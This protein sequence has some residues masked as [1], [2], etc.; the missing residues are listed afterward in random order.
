MKL[1]TP[2]PNRP[3][4]PRRLPKAPPSEGPPRQPKRSLL[5][6]AGERV[7]DLGYTLSALPKFI[8]P[9]I[10]GATA[11]Q[12]A[13]IAQSLDKLPFHHQVLPVSI[14]VLPSFSQ[15]PNYLGL[16][17]SVVGAITLN[18]SGYDMD[19]KPQF[20]H[21]VV[22]EVGHSVDYSAGQ[23]SWLS[24][25]NPSARAPYGQPAFTSEYGSTQPV[26]DFAESY[27]EH[28]LDPER[29]RRLN[30]QKANHQEQLSQP[31]LLQKWVDQ[32]AYR[33]TG[34]FIAQQFQ[35]APWMRMGL[36][37][38]RQAS[39]M[40]LATSGATQIYEGVKAK[41][42]SKI[43]SGALQ[44]AAGLTMGF[45]PAL[46]WLGVAATGLLGAQRGLDLARAEGVS[47]SRQVA[48]STAGAVGGTVGG[49][50]APLAAVP[51]GYALAG[52]IGGTVG[53]VVSGMLGGHFGATLSAKAALALTE[54]KPT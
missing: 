23:F 38:T 52:P 30:A 22:H 6:A 35:S 28:V 3:T 36:E 48:A 20:Q 32:P 47:A 21:T 53:L 2:T 33:E 42:A 39:V 34:K 49:F 10:A 4:S 12:Q 40:M 11:E 37:L 24:R 25:T 13:W 27:A 5:A 44:T 43:S 18:A 51:L 1:S 17:R 9:T 45:T 8:S 19:W 7:L 54:D 41:D 15:G 14:E 16:N 50:L 31:S 29:L 26:E 46:P